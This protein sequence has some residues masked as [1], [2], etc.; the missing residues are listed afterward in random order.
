MSRVS[1]AEQF[2]FYC[3]CGFAFTLPIS[4][5][6]GNLFLSLSLILFFYRIYFKH[7]DIQKIFFANKNIF[8]VIGLL[9]GAVLISAFSSEEFLTGLKS[10]L[11]KY[12]FHASIILPIIFITHNKEKIFSIFKFLLLGCVIN[13]SA[14]IVHALAH[15]PLT[16]TPRFGGLLGPMQE[17]SLLVMTLPIFLLIFLH[18]KDG[19]FKIF[20][21][22]L[23]LVGM[24]ALLLNGTR[25]AWLAALILLPLTV[26]IYS[27]NIKKS[28][29]A[30]FTALVLVSGIFFINSTLSSRFATITDLKMQSNSE[31]L[32]MWESAWNMFKDNPILGVGYGQY[33]TAYQTKYI[34]PEAKERELGHAHSNFFQILGECGFLGF[35]AFI[36][37]WIYFSYFAIK[38]WRREK[39]FAC[40]M[41]FCV[42][43][44]FMLHGFT[45]F[46]FETSVPSKLFWLSLALCVAYINDS[47]NFFHRI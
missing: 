39:N 6:V 46:N 1:K 36:F 38:K 31:R 32:L 33:K 28:L 30:I 10:W 35:S 41:F 3:L 17:A 27:K 22:I 23:F 7:D 25:G 5:A 16:V 47:K 13:Y 11:N 43:W 44:G 40:L 37:M 9:F 14:V 2:L 8:A 18:A 26:L 24:I 42:L 15:F 4:K 12:F 19:Q 29:I 21:A 45:E 20:S 34:L